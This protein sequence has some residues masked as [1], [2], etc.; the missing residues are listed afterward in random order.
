MRF[1]EVNNERVEL[2]RDSGSFVSIVRSALVA[3]EQYT[4][5]QVTCLL[6]DICVKNCPQAVV[7]VDTKYYKGRLPV[8]C[9]ERCIYNLIL[10][11]DIYELTSERC[12]VEQSQAEGAKTIVDM[13]FE[14]SKLRSGSPQLE[15]VCE[16]NITPTVQNG[17]DI[18]IGQNAVKVDERSK[19]EV[20]EFYTAA[21]QTRAQ[22]QA[23]QYF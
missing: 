9:M 19:D 6:V 21:V 5:K 4:G 17:R 12:D 1:G 13:I 2:L 8:V 16:K 15:A 11:N 23:V 20:E 3:A 18:V 10:G 7:E 14:N 22:K